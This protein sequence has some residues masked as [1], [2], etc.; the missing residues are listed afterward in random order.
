MASKKDSIEKLQQELATLKKQLDSPDVPSA[1]PPRFGP[2]SAEH[3]FLLSPCSPVNLMGRDLLCKL[4]ANLLCREEG[5]FV[6]LP[7]YQA[8]NLMAL[9]LSEES[10][11][12]SGHTPLLDLSDVPE[13]LWAAHVNE[14]GLLASATPVQT[15]YRH[16]KPFPR[17]ALY[18]L[19]REAQE[20]IKPVIS[21]SLNKGYLFIQLHH[22][23]HL[24]YL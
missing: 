5:I 19:A 18:L 8:P 24:Y 15:T 3:S 2:L 4:G 11:E 14:V 1:P 16:N 10:D 9:L 6:D 12:T 17:V 20:G 23:I 21:P 7:P 13:T 22:V